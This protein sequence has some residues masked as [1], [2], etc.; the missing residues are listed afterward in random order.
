MLIH[1][2]IIRKQTLEPLPPR[3]L[4]P[5]LPTNWENNLNI[6]AFVSSLTATVESCYGGTGP[7]GGTAWSLHET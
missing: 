2:K 3:I 6:H 5:F 7:P 1:D 4:D